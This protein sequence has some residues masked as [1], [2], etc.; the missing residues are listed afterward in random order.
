MLVG[1]HGSWP[2]STLTIDGTDYEV[3]AS[4]TGLYLTHSTSALS[5]TAQV[6]AHMDTELGGTNTVVMLK[7]G[8]IRVTASSGTF[9]MNFT[10]ALNATM[11]GFTQ[12]NLSGAATYTADDVSPFLFRPGRTD[13]PLDARL[14]SQG[15]PVWDVVGGVS[16]DGTTST[17]V[18]GS[19]RL[20][21][22]RFPLVAAA[23]YWDEDDED[24]HFVGWW[25]NVAIY[26]RK[27]FH[28]RNVEED[29]ASTDPISLGTGIGPYVINMT[30]AG[31]D[32]PFK[33]HASHGQTEGYYDVDLPMF[34]TPEYAA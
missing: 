30:K 26:G 14:G 19:Q 11:G 16:R 24:R 2:S 31:G 8:K 29:D 27:F 28:Y 9:T 34:L 32:L 3:T 20:Q 33:R 10:D 18:L 13:T 12:G 25:E 17:R 6:K 4:L 22:I 1:S 15:R 23:R 5:W 21:T 7:N